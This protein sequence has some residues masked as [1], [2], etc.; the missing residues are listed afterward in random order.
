[1]RWRALNRGE[2]LASR[3][4]TLRE[5]FANGVSNGSEDAYASSVG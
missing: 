3:E 4:S 2:R 1:M 5:V